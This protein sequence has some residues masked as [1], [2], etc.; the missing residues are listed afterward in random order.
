[1]RKSPASLMR[2]TQ[3]GQLARFIEQPTVLV[4]TAHEVEKQRNSEHAVM[5]YG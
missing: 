2:P 3:Q 1:M 4:L 5:V